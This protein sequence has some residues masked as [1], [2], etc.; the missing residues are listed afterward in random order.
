MAAAAAA[1]RLM[2][3]AGPVSALAARLDGRAVS[4]A[5]GFGVASA[6]S[7]SACS[8]A[9]RAARASRRTSARASAAERRSARHAWKRS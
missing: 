4:A 2:A 9:S 5:T 8:S 3:A 1:L 6:A 7:A